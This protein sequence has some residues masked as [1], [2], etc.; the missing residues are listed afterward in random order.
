VPEALRCG[1]GGDKV[2][3]PTAALRRRQC[4][5]AGRGDDRRM[6]THWRKQLATGEGLGQSKSV[7]THERRGV[8]SDLRMT[9][10]AIATDPSSR[11]GP[12]QIAPAATAQG[13]CT[14]MGRAGSCRRAR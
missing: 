8:T 13:S 1:D 4:Q 3:H 14:Q 10:G 9:L 11:Q 12:D 6:H 7:E 5:D 2:E